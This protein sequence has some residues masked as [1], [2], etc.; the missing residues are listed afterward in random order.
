M[1]YPHGLLLQPF[2]LSLPPLFQYVA[3]LFCPV[4][5]RSRDKVDRI[6]DAYVGV[7]HVRKRGK[8]K[9]YNI[10]NVDDVPTIIEK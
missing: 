1:T 4:T 2:D 8:M 9:S 5:A 3:P 10:Y 6:V 7:W